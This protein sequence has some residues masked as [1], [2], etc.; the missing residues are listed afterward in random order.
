MQLALR[1]VMRGGAGFCLQLR[2]PP[3]LLDYPS[4]QWCLPSRGCP[5]DFSSPAAHVVCLWAR[6]HPCHERAGLSRALCVLLGPCMRILY[7][8]QTKQNSVLC[9]AGS[10]IPFSFLS[11]RI[12]DLKIRAMLFVEGVEPIYLTLVKAA[13]VFAEQQRAGPKSLSQ[14]PAVTSPGFSHP[15]CPVKIVR[16]GF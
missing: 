15:D 6:R 12:T 7:C 13:A 14:R 5:Q 1:C 10:L 3:S 16:D 4:A 11:L 9:C 8:F 2:L